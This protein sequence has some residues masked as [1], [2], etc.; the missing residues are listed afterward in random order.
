MP[1][2][3][4]DFIIV[5]E[6]QLD[7]INQNDIPWPN[8]FSSR[9]G[10]FYLLTP[11]PVDIPNYK[12]IVLTDH[13]SS[14]S[15]EISNQT[16]VLYTDWLASKNIF[17]SSNLITTF[18]GSTLSGSVNKRTLKELQ[19]ISYNLFGIPYLTEFKRLQ[20]YEQL[21]I[22]FAQNQILSQTNI[23]APNLGMLNS[24]GSDG[25][26]VY[27]HLVRYLKIRKVHSKCIIP[28]T[29]GFDSRFLLLAASEVY[30]LEN[31]ITSTLQIGGQNCF[32]TL[33]ARNLSERLDVPWIGCKSN[34]TDHINNLFDLYYKYSLSY[35]GAYYFD[36]AHQLSNKLNHIDQYDIL[37]GLVG[38]AWSGK[39]S[40]CSKNEV[41][42]RHHNGIASTTTFEKLSTSN[43]I[44][45]DYNSFFAT[46]DTPNL[47]SNST[48]LKILVAA[49]I[50]HLEFLTKAFEHYGCSVLT[51][52]TDLAIVSSILC[53]PPKE[54]YKRTWQK[55]FFASRN[56]D[57]QPYSTYNK[58]DYSNR[59]LLK[60]CLNY[61]RKVKRLSQSISS[62]SQL[63]LYY[64]YYLFM[65]KHTLLIYSEFMILSN[66]FSRHLLIVC[67]YKPLLFNLY[68]LMR[69]L[70]LYNK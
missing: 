65:L 51:P 36:F 7:N 70:S 34:C 24:N 41:I 44:Y 58:P 33:A 30:G 5:L 67:R 20:A 32:E 25:N 45:N 10:S 21:S 11:S 66:R 47:A 4:N 49:K 61:S 37:S 54:R 35:N 40:I 28:L 68:A 56:L 57:Y 59:Y 1:L 62:P 48:L 6:S 19:D 3:L 53:L 13:R 31:I 17:Y 2:F 39:V 46:T 22:D 55:K 42:H 26:L 69:T 64:M 16:V 52:F 9:I 50:P 38:D 63:P 15:L 23:P 8:T 43:Q 18:L 14:Y 12:T 29:A 27:N 60:Y